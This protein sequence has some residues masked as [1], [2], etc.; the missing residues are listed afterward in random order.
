GEVS[1]AIGE[2]GEASYGSLL[3][4]LQAEVNAALPRQTMATGR[5]WFDYLA[6]RYGA[7]NV[8]WVA[9]SGRTATWPGGLPMP[10]GTMFRTPSPVRSSQFVRD[11][12]SVAGPRPAD[13]A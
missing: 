2:L 12:E 8:E 9:G 6:S 4:G 7:E 3:R 10:T 1:A 13:S 5:E 11:L